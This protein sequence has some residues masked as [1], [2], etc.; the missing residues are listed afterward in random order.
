MTLAGRAILLLAAP[1]LTATHAL[2]AGKW[3]LTYFHDED[4]SSLVLNG[5]A[6]SS[7]QC[8]VAI[9]AIRSAGKAKPVA[10]V[11]ADGG[12]SWTVH[13]LKSAPHSVQ[14]LTS[15]LGFLAAE[16]GVWRTGDC[17]RT[18]ERISRLKG[19]V[20]VHFLDERQGFAAGAP[21]KA[22]RTSDG[23]QS[24]RDLEIENAPQ[25]DPER[26]VY[27]NI[28]FTDD[29]FG[30]IGGW[31]KPRRPASPSG[32]PVWM[33]PE[34]AGERRQWP[35]LTLML[36]TLDFGKTWRGFSSSILGQ[37]T[38]IQL[39]GDVGLTLVEFEQ[40]FDWPCE[41]YRI[42]IRG[43][44]SSRIFREKDRAI[45]DIALPPGGSALLAGFEPVGSLHQLPVPGKVRILGSEDLRTF[46]EFPVDY[47]AVARRVWLAA[48]PSGP[49]LAATDTGMILRLDEPAK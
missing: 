48:P 16:D 43:G 38:R 26:S 45:T 41:V 2:P 10:V 24:W 21:K 40:S 42:H 47:R 36:Q 49:P 17:G 23:G 30:M 29:G 32:L 1:V 34:S 35:S 20:R 3:K 6:A 13:P 33:D 12:R 15:R 27:A 8:A 14:M 18:W 37:M 28:A 25:A 9:G 44:E 4:K 19:I 5:I 39:R 7:P 46:H 22:L 31:H 11:S